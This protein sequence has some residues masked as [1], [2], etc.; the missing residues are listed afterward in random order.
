M[1]V[2]KNVLFNSALGGRNKSMKNQNGT[3]GELQ[4]IYKKWCQLKQKE[5]ICVSNLLRENYIKFVLEKERK[6]NKTE[7]EFIVAC[8]YLDIQ[9]KKIFISVNEVRKY[10][11]SRI[12]KY[13]KSIEKAGL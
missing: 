2:E 12:E 4:Q 7:K 5:Q 13:D 9:E 11:E 6:P 3:N 8:A 1:N 10:F